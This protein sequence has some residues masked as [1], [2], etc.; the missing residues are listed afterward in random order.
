M[1]MFT[2]IVFALDAASVVLVVVVVVVVAIAVGEATDLVAVVVVVN[3]FYVW[4]QLY[5][6][7]RVSGVLVPWTIRQ[8]KLASRLHVQ[9]R[10]CGADAVHTVNFVI[11]VMVSLSYTEFIVVGDR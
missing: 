10:E 4:L 1:D 6:V 11:T 7:S 2:S 3:I 5:V 9:T 8:L